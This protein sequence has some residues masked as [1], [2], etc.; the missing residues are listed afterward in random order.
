MSNKQL[1]N[2]Q[3]KQFEYQGYLRLGK[4]L[5]DTELSTLQERI[6]D[7]MM[8]RAALNYEQMLM[9]LDR[10]P[11]YDSPGPQTKGH[12]GATL[13]YRK[14][15]GLE[16]DPHFLD[17][18]RKP[19]FRHI[20]TRA[21]GEKK[22]IACF[23]AMF[24]NKPAR[25]GTNLNWHQ[26]RWNYLDRDPLI[27]IWTALDPATIENG[28]VKI[29]QG[30]HHKLVNPTSKAGHLTEGQIPELLRDAEV[31]YLELA[32]GESVLLH[33]HLPHASEVNNTDIPRRAFS[34]CYMDAAT[35]TTGDETYTV[36]FGEGALEL[37]N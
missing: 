37:E 27:T 17:F 3:W 12:K 15:Q 5:G 7:I 26:D 33:N 35:R 25:E 23:R 34:V 21:Y 14:I 1:S 8:G 20:C 10:E 6:D 29:V 30:T 4:I 31:V 2:E 22:D 16:F 11:G 36:L 9:Q 13:S 19:L 28:C 18:M 32:A 24:M